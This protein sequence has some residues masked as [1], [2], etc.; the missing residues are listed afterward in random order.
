MNSI[1]FMSDEVVLK[2]R[3]SLFEECYLRLVERNKKILHPASY[4][5][6]SHPGNNLMR[7]T[8][9]CMN[10]EH[11]G[12]KEGLEGGWVS[13]SIFLNTNTYLL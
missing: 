9:W 5:H 8:L 2:L 6:C 3:N 1:R 12:H 11:R 7:L 13:K 10:I 4:L